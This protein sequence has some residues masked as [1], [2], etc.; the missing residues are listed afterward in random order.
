MVNVYLLV[1]KTIG[2][3]KEFREGLKVKTSRLLKAPSFNFDIA[4]KFFDGASQNNSSRGG[5]G[6]VLHL[7]H[8]NFFHLKLALG[9]CTSTKA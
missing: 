3:F 6:M 9:E 7:A 2:A 1:T 4:Q 8:N 5:E